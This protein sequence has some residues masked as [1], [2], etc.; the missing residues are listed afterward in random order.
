MKHFHK[1]LWILFLFINCVSTSDESTTT[2]S[3]EEISGNDTNH[4]N[5]TSEVERYKIMHFHFGGVA[6][7]YIIVLWILVASLSK[8]AFHLSDRLTKI[9]PES[10]LLLVVGLVVGTFIY[11]ADRAEENS[12]RLTF[13]LFFFYLLPP[14]VIEAGYFLPTRA[15]LDNLGTILWFAIGN[16]LFNTLTIGFFLYALAEAGTFGNNDGFGL[17]A[18]LTFSAIISAVDPVAVIATFEEVQVNDMLYII[19]FGESLLNDAVSVVLYRMFNEYAKIGQS[20]IKV[21]DVFAGIGSFFVSSIGGVLVGGAYAILVGFITKFTLHSQIFE[22]LIVMSLAYLS[23]LTAEM[24]SFSAILAAAFCGL[25]MK[26]YVKYNIAP[27]SHITLTYTLKMTSNVM[28]SIIFMFLGVSTVSRDHEFNAAFVFLTIFACLF[29]RILGVLIFTAIVNPYRLKPLTKTDVIVMSYGGLRGAVAFAL[30]TVLQLKD[31]P[32]KRVFV[33]ATICVVFF[34]VVVQGTTITPLVNYLKV[35]RKEEYEPTIGNVLNTRLIDHVMAGIEDIVGM[36]GENAIRAYIRHYDK[37]VF[38]PMLLREKTKDRDVKILTELE[39]INLRLATEVAKKNERPDFS[40]NLSSVPTS[41]NLQNDEDH[42]MKI[43]KNHI[44]DI[45]FEENKG[46][47]EKD[48]RRY[49]T[50]SVV[51]TSLPPQRI[52]EQS[53]LDPR[54]RLV[55]QRRGTVVE[56]NDNLASPIHHHERMWL[57]RFLNTEDHFPQS[58]RNSMRV[59]ERRAHLKDRSNTTRIPYNEDHFGGRNLR[60]RSSKGN[61][62]LRSITGG[63]FRKRSESTNSRK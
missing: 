28:E 42:L 19:V 15:F 63:M 47:A 36:R 1:L 27:K 14:I 26:Q 16:T 57:R 46:G 30:A 39:D 6:D 35:R 21:I 50:N 60:N 49:R 33:T 40:H 29:F 44:G 20:D 52:L 13:D 43:I 10:C 11:F 48:F 31:F 56:L 51:E 22:P 8:L 3:I 24:L 54:K 9:F 53:L 62:R 61:G 32:A 2:S 34:T 5:E 59:T 23:Y 58:I 7:P 41:L 38:K 55:F 45:S 4:G 37:N 12:Y 25:I 18:C 17:L